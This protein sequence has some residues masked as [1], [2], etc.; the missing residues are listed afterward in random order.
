MWVEPVRDAIRIGTEIPT[1]MPCILMTELRRRRWW[2]TTEASQRYSF[3]LSLVLAF[4]LSIFGLAWFLTSFLFLC[5]RSP[6][7][8]SLFPRLQ[9]HRSAD[10][11]LVLFLFGAS[12]YK[13]RD[14][15][16]YI[17]KYMSSRTKSPYCLAQPRW[18]L[19][20][21]SLSFRLYS[22]HLIHSTC[23]SPSGPCQ[24]AHLFSW[25]V[26]WCRPTVSFCFFFLILFWPRRVPIV[27]SSCQ[28]STI[29]TSTNP[30][31]CRDGPQLS[32]IITDVVDTACHQWVCSLCVKVR[33]VLSL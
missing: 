24:P 4:W 20:L 5:I 9:H 22:F 25:I 29:Q 3:S 6:I 16:K 21:Y 31:F 10:Y 18:L 8:L 11:T 27:L 14:I 28:G 32:D 12:V 1:E 19:T 33:V 15:N 7:R 30:P 23:S 2:K 17:Y 26:G 13:D